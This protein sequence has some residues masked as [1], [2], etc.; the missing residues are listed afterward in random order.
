MK[1]LLAKVN[2]YDSLKYPVDGFILGFEN[3]SYC[4]EKY[5]NLEEI[6]KIIKENPFK[7]FF[8][9]VN[10][11]ITN[12]KLDEYKEI[13]KNIDSL[14]VKGIIVGDVAALTYNLK[15]NLI[16]DQL[17]LNNSSLS[18]NHYYNNNV[19]G[20]FLTNDITLQEINFIR[21]NTKSILFKEVFGLPHLSTSLRKLISNYLEYFN[22]KNRT[23]G[24]YISENNSNDYYHIVENDSETHIFG[25]KVLNLFE[26]ID[27]INVDYLI[28]NDFLLDKKKFMKVVSIF[29][30]NDKSK[31]K[32]IKELF[33][34]DDGFIHKK[35]MYKVKD[36]E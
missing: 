4:F 6:K 28:I 1:K 26:Y 16:L 3:Y 17:H 10:K 34:T 35:T 13:L 8:I 18:I 12:D 11:I 31:G 25:N 20:V 32:K 22:V 9:S 24:Y 14:N 30:E 7:E 33:D 27:D 21:D 15:T 19:K 29:K 5:F 2:S 23:K 36:N